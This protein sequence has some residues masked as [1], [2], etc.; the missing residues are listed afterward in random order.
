MYEGRRGKIMCV[1]MYTGVYRTS[2][3]YEWC[4][5]F[6]S[7][8][9]VLLVTKGMTTHEPWEAQYFSLDS[10]TSTAGTWL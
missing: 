5:E 7:L 1:Y 3:N 9:S 6:P 4:Y 2:V 10:W 8:G